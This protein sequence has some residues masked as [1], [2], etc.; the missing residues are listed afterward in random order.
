MT[1]L[2]VAAGALGAAISFFVLGFQAPPRPAGLQPF[3]G[4]VVPGAVVT[5]PFGCTSFEWE[6]ADAEC[7][8][9]HFHSGIDLAAPEGTPV[10][11]PFA[12]EVIHVGPAGGCGIHVTLRHRQG[13]E[14]LYC[15]LSSASVH[16]GDRL[17]AGDGVGR[18]GST[19]NSTGPHLHL[20]VHVNG[21]AVD[22]SPWLAQLPADEPNP[23]RQT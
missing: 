13:L 16:P 18:V 14:T 11:A 7:P 2:K 10:Y 15:H 21:R 1:A 22:P 20:E 12:G 9:G 5:L 3:P 4:V 17:L 6:P 8:E 19:G 23:G